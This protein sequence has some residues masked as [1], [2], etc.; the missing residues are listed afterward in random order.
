MW[1]K[2]TPY[3]TLFF[4]GGKPFTM[5][6]DNWSDFIF[7]PNPSTLY[8]AVRSWLIFER[9]S[10][11]DF[12]EGRLKEDLGTVEDKGKLRIKGPF[13]IEEGKLLFPLP[14]DL[15]VCKNANV[16]EKNFTHRLSMLKKPG[17]F[18]SDYNLENILI[19]KD[20]DLIEAD[21]FL[22]ELYFKE[23]LEGKN[24]VRL[25][26]KDKVFLLESK[27]GIARDNKTKTAKEGCL[28]N[29]PMVRLKDKVSI[30]FKLEEVE[31]T[32]VRFSMKFGG[33]G[34]I[35]EVERLEKNPIK[36]IEEININDIVKNNIFKLYLATPAIFEKGYLPSWID[37]NTF[38]GEYNGV[39]LRLICCVVG[40]SR[41]VGGW[42]IAKNEPKPMYRAVPAGS[43][44]YFEIINGSLEDLKRLFHFQNISDIYPEEGYGL[45][46]IGGVK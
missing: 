35:V 9:G 24:S 37:E 39:K 10:L 36:E 3:D 1:Y 6:D 18:V 42:D 30:A 5:G 17:I 19:T 2:F 13:L 31:A 43:V 12:K 8:G 46:F 15:L 20:N 16:K 34:K 21:G 14:Q 25:K 28:Y 33:E 7:P 4:R 38:E 26:P 32:S 40:K 29:I 23:Y 44:Y 27:I 11:K 22:E 45:S 41:P